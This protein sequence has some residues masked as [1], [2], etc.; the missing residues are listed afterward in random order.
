MHAPLIR[1]SADADDLPGARAQPASRAR[2]RLLALICALGVAAAPL[3]APG[4]AT[5]VA[6]PGQDHAWNVTLTSTTAGSHPDISATLN[7]CTDRTGLPGVTHECVPGSPA[8]SIFDQWTIRYTGLR[9]G[10]PPIAS[11]V[12][13]VTLDVETNLGLLQGAGNEKGQPAPCG[14]V[15]HSP[16][17]LFEMWAASTDGPPVSMDAS[18]LTGFAYDQ[19]DDPGQADPTPGG[20]EGDGW[21]MG[22]SHVPAVV[23]AILA[24]MGIPQSA[25]ISRGYGVATGV[26]HTTITTVT[27]FTGSAQGTDPLSTIIVIGNPFGAHDSAQSDFM[28][29]APGSLTLVMRGTTLDSA[30]SKAINGAAVSGDYSVPAAAGTTLLTLC[31]SS[32]PAAT[33][34]NPAAR[35]VSLLLST[36]GDDDRDGVTDAADDCPTVPSAGQ[37]N[38]A[39]IGD[40]CGGPLGVNAGTGYANND[41]AAIAAF[42]AAECSGLPYSAAKAV[43]CADI[44]G[45]GIKNRSDNCPFAPNATQLNRDGDSR[46]DACE[47]DGTDPGITGGGTNAEAFTPG[48]FSGLYRDF[49]DRCDAAYSVGGALSAVTTCSSFTATPGSGGCCT[50]P[51]APFTDSDDNG[52]PDYLLTGGISVTRDHRADANGDGY[53]DAD[54]GTPADCGVAGCAGLTSY[55]TAE[56]GSCKDSGRSCGTIVASPVGAPRTASAGAGLG[57]WRSIDSSGP[58]TTVT[59]A[60]SDV[61]LDGS[62]SI[63][64][65]SMV[66]AWIGDKVGAADDPRWEGNLDGDGFISILD[67]ARMASNYGRS[68]SLDCQAA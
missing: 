62:V 60:Q 68:V 27:V 15:F 38:F 51:N 4:P 23:P 25:L 3:I 50:G 8:P 40:A 16:L 33:A 35:T 5:A 6:P 18:P 39:G 17:P 32:L 43:A 63:L 56:T 57:C 31:D 52:V 19:L 1:P 13:T 24:A 22:I 49:D 64:D 65:L 59:L 11:R 37:P 47:G 54:E 34:C 66:A 9:A 2:R 28:N 41:A 45:D 7:M 53:S 30:G 10:S 21:P 42:S 26:G 14:S 55:A 61:D 58:A 36:Y 46:G 67:L 12:A 48:D 29:C 20:A 44:D